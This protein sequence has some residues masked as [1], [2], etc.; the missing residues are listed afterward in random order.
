LPSR[1]HAVLSVSP[2]LLRDATRCPDAL[3]ALTPAP[4]DQRL[5]W[6]DGCWHAVCACRRVSGACASYRWTPYRR[7]GPKAR[8]RRNVTM[9]PCHD[10]QHADLLL[11]GHAWQFATLHDAVTT[12]RKLRAYRGAQ[13][14]D[15]PA[16]I[17]RLF[18]DA[19][20]V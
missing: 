12:Y 5:C 13:W 11:D 9:Q 10:A 3:P 2:R 16:T 17:R 20:A 6:H 8:T 15:F 14:P 1:A 18:A 7:C 19:S 4:A